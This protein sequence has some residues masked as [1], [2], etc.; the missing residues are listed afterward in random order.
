MVE[1]LKKNYME[2][3]KGL[4][5]VLILSLTLFSLSLTKSALADGASL[6]LSPASESFLIGD[7]FSVEVKVDTGGIPINAAHAHIHFSSEELEVAN[8]S[9]ENSIFSLWPGEPAVFDSDEEYIY[10]AGGLPQPGFNGI[11]KIITIQFKAKK[12]GFV[13]LDLCETKVLACDGEGTDVLVFIKEAKYSIQEKAPLIGM[14]P[15]ILPGQLPPAPQIFSSTHSLQEEWYNNN[16]IGFQ[17]K[18][19]P[20]VTGISF[21]LDN[22]PDTIPDINPEAR[23]ESKNYEN[24]EDGV[25][26]FH[27]RL[28]NEEGWGSPAHY[29]AQ[30]D[31]SPPEPF[32]ITIDNG[33]DPTNPS[34]NLYFETDD[35][36]SGI[37]YYKFKIGEERFSKLMVAQINPFSLLHLIPGEHLITV[38]AA[39]QAGNNVETEAVIGIEPIT[40]P[41]IILWPEFHVSGEEVFY[42][43]G[44]ALPETQIMIFLKKDGQEIKKWQVQANTQGEWSFFTKELIKSGTYYLSAQTEDKRGAVSNISDSYEI[45]ISLS[46]ISL[47][48]LIISHRTL[49][50]ILLLIVFL[51]V[52][53][54]GYFACKIRRTKKILRKETRE[55][56]EILHRTFDDLKKEIEK[57]IEMFDSQPG[58]SKKEREVYEDLKKVLN[59]SEESIRKEIRDVEKELE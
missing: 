18:L 2:N 1:K 49:A 29:K 23:S 40:T 10:F 37:K 41:Q 7:T 25:W 22:N 58:F 47:G 12:E 14:E 52:I 5:F 4:K 44:K 21:V 20:E 39:D 33:G 46:G 6:F 32:E 55:A 19:V 28:A 3:R 57:R 50:L 30:I 54:T 16:N 27:L 42:I 36:I 8:I 43:E 24:V 11:G 13:G 17:W 53:I 45:K 35:E 15:K 26:Y 34:P 31:V 51:G 48:S 9:K 56:E 38:W 59:V